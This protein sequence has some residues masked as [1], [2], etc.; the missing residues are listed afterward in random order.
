MRCGATSFV[1]AMGNV[2]DEA[3][4]EF[5]A[6]FYAELMTGAIV[7][8]ALR[9]ARARTARTARDADS[10]T[11]SQLPVPPAEPQRLLRVLKHDLFLV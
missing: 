1:G 6:A 4:A 3:G 11:S 7:A 8:E 5:A 2:A 10:G 9:R